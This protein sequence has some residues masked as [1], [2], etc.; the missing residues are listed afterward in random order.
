VGRFRLKTSESKSPPTRPHQ[1]LFRDGR[2]PRITLQGNAFRTM[3]IM[4]GRLFTHTG[5]IT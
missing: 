3:T 4:E 1:I 2:V 5:D